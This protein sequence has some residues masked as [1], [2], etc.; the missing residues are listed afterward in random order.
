MKR[1][2]H[3]TGILTAWLSALLL[4]AS[5]VTFFV[6]YYLT[7]YLPFMLMALTVLLPS[8]IYTWLLLVGFL[9]APRPRDAE[10]GTDGIPPG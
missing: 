9:R 8:V 5:S 4:L 10:A 3:K 1:S 6:F 2:D 7:R